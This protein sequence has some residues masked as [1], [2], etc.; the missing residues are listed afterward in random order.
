LKVSEKA[1]KKPSEEFI[2]LIETVG[3]SIGNLRNLI[4]KVKQKGGEEGFSDFEIVLLSREI[5]ANSLTRRQLNYWLPLRNRKSVENCSIQ[6]P[7]LVK[8]DNKKALEQSQLSHTLLPVRT[9]DIPLQDI[10]KHTSNEVDTEVR[11]NNERGTIRSNICT[12]Q[13]G[14]LSSDPVCAN[15]SESNEFPPHP[16][17]L[18]L[19]DNEETIQ[20]KG[21]VASKSLSI[22]ASENANIRLF[23][24]PKD[25][26]FINEHF[27]PRI[28][29][30]DAIVY[31]QHFVG[32]FRK[33][34]F[35]FKVIE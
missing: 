25:C 31:L 10:Q 33:I 30:L 9:L 14:D 15:D 11:R 16:S 7:P 17:A 28:K 5:L 12:I 20:I 13:T 3:T 35:G 19:Q 26:D 23:Q 24:I 6:L 21:T 34:D 27:K 4:E 29:P 18:L 1:D 8:N 2:S 22:S 32:K